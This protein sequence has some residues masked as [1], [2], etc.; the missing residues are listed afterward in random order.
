MQFIFGMIP[1]DYIL[2]I[3]SINFLKNIFAPSKWN[4]Y[5]HKVLLDSAVQMFTSLECQENAASHT[6][7]ILI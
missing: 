3:K 1:N 2:D 6:E 5:Y 4:W 7:S